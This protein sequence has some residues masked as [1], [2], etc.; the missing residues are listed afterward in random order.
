MHGHL[1]VESVNTL[2][3][4]S[5]IFRCKNCDKITC[6]KTAT[7]P[8]LKEVQEQLFSVQLALNM[9]SMT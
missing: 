8:S 9:L 1:N 3:A 7:Q 4:F 5:H 6:K 2:I